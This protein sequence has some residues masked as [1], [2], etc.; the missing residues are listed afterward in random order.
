MNK[1][2]L[3]FNKPKAV[4]GKILFPANYAS[5]GRGVSVGQPSALSWNLV[6]LV[7]WWLPV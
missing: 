6:H 7:V 3:L 5:T 1:V 4:S 2:S